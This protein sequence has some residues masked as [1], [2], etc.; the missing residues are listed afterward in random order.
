M[1]QSRLS[2]K[3]QVTI[4][5]EI[6]ERLALEPGD[7]VVYEIEGDRAIL[8]RG[9]PIDAAF[10]AAISATLDEWGSDEDDEAFRDL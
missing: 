8:R 4:P 9:D 6:R 3:G 10:H 1:Y 7:L 2:G 5:V